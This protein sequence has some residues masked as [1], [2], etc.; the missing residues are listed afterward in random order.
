MVTYADMAACVG[1]PRIAAG[2]GH[3]VQVENP[4]WVASL[5]NEAVNQ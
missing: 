4:T 3:N 1:E 5:I 2:C